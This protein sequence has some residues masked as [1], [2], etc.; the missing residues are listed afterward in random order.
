MTV[1]YKKPEKIDQMGWRL[2]F[3]SDKT[4]PI[5]FRVYVAGEKVTEFISATKDSEIYLPIASGDHP[6]IEVMDADCAP[7]PA[8]PGRASIYWFRVSGATTYRVERNISS[9]W[10]LEAEVPDD[11]RSYFLWASGWLADV[12]SHQLRVVPVD[13]AGN[14]GST[15]TKNILLVRHPDVPNVTYAYNSGPKTV[16]ISAA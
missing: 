3:S 1:T 15:T 13:D 2:K 12:T 8:G 14:Q 11:G 4:A 6:F 9:V 5:T 10:T 7:E 16:T